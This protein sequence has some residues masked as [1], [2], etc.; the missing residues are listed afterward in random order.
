M[1]SATRRSAGG[2]HLPEDLLTRLRDRLMV[3]RANQAAQADRHRA[4]VHELAG[5]WDF[6]SLL[7]REIA[8]VGAHRALQAV[9][10]ID[11]ALTHLVDRTYG[12][13]EL[14]G[15]RIPDERLDAIPY[16]RLCVECPGRQASPNPAGGPAT[17]KARR[18]RRLASVVMTSPAEPP[19]LITTAGTP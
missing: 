8:E 15:S 1:K 7:E 3:E 18:P 13:C 5:H 6:D 19:A 14:C 12:T 17:A 9:A 11:R 16:A 4:T 10:D 2:A